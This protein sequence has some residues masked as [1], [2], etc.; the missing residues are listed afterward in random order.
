MKVLA[1]EGEEVYDD[2]GNVI[3]HLDMYR[4]RFSD[5]SEIDAWGEEVCD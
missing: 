4:I 3:D 2:D 1:K 5:G